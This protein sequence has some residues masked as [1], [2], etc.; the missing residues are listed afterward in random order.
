MPSHAVDRREFKRIAL[1]MRVVEEHAAGRSEAQAVDLCELGIRYVKP[2]SAPR[3]PDREV[4]L[5]FCLPGDARP[6][7]VLGWIAG[8][9]V[10][11]EARYL[12]VT[13]A[14]PT[15]EDAARVT[16]LLSRARAARL[17]RVDA[18]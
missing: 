9:Q 17:R 8:E 6:V 10:R 12:S 1:T 3:C 18:R 15:D 4:M 5:E 16:R 2:A 13:F 11:R 7:H 14:F